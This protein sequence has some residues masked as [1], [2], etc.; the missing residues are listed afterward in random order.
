MTV[1]FSISLCATCIGVMIEPWLAIGHFCSHCN[2][3]IMAPIVA[4]R[5]YDEMEVNRINVG[6]LENFIVINE[7]ADKY[8]NVDSVLIDSQL[9]KALEESQLIA[10]WFWITMG[11]LLFE[12]LALIFFVLAPLFG[13]C[14]QHDHSS[15]YI[16]VADNNAKIADDSSSSSSSSSHLSAKYYPAEENE[17]AE[18]V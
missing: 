5:M 16:K 11:M 18:I 10:V 1:I 3:I 15:D 13:K 7:C 6:K 8:T 2:Y 12:V 17:K 14:C 9:D 4:V